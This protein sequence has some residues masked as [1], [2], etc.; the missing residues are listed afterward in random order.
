MDFTYAVMDCGDMIRKY[1]WSS[2]EAKWYQDTHKD[3]QVIRLPKAPKENVFD[4]IKAEP[5]F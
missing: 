3:I 2:K 1:R 5:L 4:L